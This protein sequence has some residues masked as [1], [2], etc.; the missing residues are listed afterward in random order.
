MKNQMYIISPYNLPYYKG[1]LKSVTSLF[2]DSKLIDTTLITVNY[3]IQNTK[4]KTSIIAN[5]INKSPGLLVFIR[6]YFGLFMFI[7]HNI[8]KKNHCLIPEFR[9]PNFISFMILKLAGCKNIIV[10]IAGQE[11]KDEGSLSSSL[12][13]WLLKY[14]D[15]VIALNLDTYNELK[16]L[17]ANPVYIPNAVNTKRFKFENRNFEKI[18]LLNVGEICPRKNSLLVINVYRKLKSIGL[19]CDLTIVG[20]ILKMNDYT[21]EFKNL[22]E[23]NLDITWVENTDNIES[24]YSTHN[25]FLFPSKAEGMPNALLEAASSGL[26]CTVSD[27]PGNREI[28][29]KYCGVLIGRESIEDYV[30]AISNT[31]TDFKLNAVNNL[32]N[33]INEI[34]SPSRAINHYLNLIND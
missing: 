4:I 1:W 19:D 17:R 26:F 11:Y 30:E 33:R 3:G 6:Y 27:I 21:E 9:F 14:A 8:E 20:P 7:R 16:R 34:H 2:E 22:I 23:T 15:K 10:R 24:F 29:S 5:S 32:R 13:R 25:H 28:V 18:K 31:T 12:R